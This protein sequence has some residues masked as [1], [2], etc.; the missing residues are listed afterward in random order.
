[1]R[2]W[3]NAVRNTRNTNLATVFGVSA[4]PGEIP[5]T[6]K[7]TIGGWQ[8]GINKYSKNID[9]AIRFVKFMT[10]PA[11]LKERALTG[12]YMPRK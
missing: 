11:E 5:G 8:L 1:M 4:L 2:N 7:G 6:G 12:S 3:P 9:A 10:S